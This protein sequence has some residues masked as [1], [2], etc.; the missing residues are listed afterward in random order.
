MASSDYRVGLVGVGRMGANMARRLKDRGFVLVGVHDSDEPRA[1]ELA[2]EL[3]CEACV[4]PARLAS[5]AN[6][7]LTVVSD[8]A[9]MRQIFSPGGPESLL[10]H[11][12]DRL[13]INCATLSPAI[14]L[15]IQNPS[16]NAKAA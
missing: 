15:E 1:Q 14:H 12:K 10:R 4:S 7:V 2:K 11:A 6:I 13:L 5:L 3:D 9:A 16:S 8:D